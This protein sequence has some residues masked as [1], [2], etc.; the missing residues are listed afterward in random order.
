MSKFKLTLKPSLGGTGRTGSRRR[1]S[2]SPG[3]P[4]GSATFGK[5]E[6]VYGV[7]G[8]HRVPV[9]DP[10]PTIPESIRALLQ[11]PVTTPPGTGWRPERPTSDRGR[12]SVSVKAP[13]HVAH[14][15][16]LQKLDETDTPTGDVRAIATGIFF[17]RQ[18]W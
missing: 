9:Q 14:L 13:W 11:G 1:S 3:G 16:A 8:T 7:T 10:L 18:A 15:T 2:S 6:A 5:A 17:F 12:A 4:L